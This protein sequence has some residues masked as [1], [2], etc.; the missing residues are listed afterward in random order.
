[1]VGLIIIAI[2]FYDLFQTVVLPRPS[3]PGGVQLARKVVRP[4]WLMWRWVSQRTS[5]LERSESRLAAFA[6]IALL[7]LFFIWASALVVGYGGAL[8]GFRNRSALPRRT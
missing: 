2:V 8:D 5:R 3:V 4:M 7:T 1:M 6:P